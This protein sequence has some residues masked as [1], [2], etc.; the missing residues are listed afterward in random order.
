MNPTPYLW[1]MHYMHNTTLGIIVIQID[2]YYMNPAYDL[3][4]KL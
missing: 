2:V 1:A 3:V 4:R